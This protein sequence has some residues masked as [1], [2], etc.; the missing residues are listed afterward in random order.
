MSKNILLVHF[1]AA[2]ANIQN[3]II[4]HDSEFMQF[5]VLEAE[6]LKIGQLQLW[7]EGTSV[8]SWQKSRARGYSKKGA[9][10]VTPPHK[11][12]PL[13]YE[14]TVMKTNTRVGLKMNKLP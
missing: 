12:L 13:L 5:M 6:C 10:W 1:P 11:N 4:Y 3:L 9:K 14:P 7:G 8:T 2:R